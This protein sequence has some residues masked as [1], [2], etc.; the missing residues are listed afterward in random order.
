MQTQFLL[1]NLI[2]SI[3]KHTKNASS[4]RTGLTRAVCDV[5]YMKKIWSKYESIPNSYH[6]KTIEYIKEQGHT[7]ND[8]VWCASEKV[9]GANFSLMTNGVDVLAGSRTQILN[10]KTKFYGGWRKVMDAEKDKVIKAFKLLNERY[11]DKI[12]VVIIY[13]EL[14]GGL[15]SHF[16]QKYMAKNQ[17]CIQKGV[18]YSPSLH[19]YAFDIK[20]DLEMNQNEQKSDDEKTDEIDGRLSVKESIE[21]FEECGFL[22]AKILKQ[23]SFE[24]LMKFDVD[25]MQSTIPRLLNLPPPTDVNTKKEVDNIAE[26]IVIRKL[27]STDHILLK[28]KEKKFLEIEESARQKGKNKKQKNKQRNAGSL[29]DKLEKI[30]ENVLKFTDEAFCEFIQ[31]C[32]NDQ[33]LQSVE[34]KIGKL[35]TEN[36]KKIQGMF[37]GDV[38]E[39]LKKEKSEI[40]SG[41]Q[42]GQIGKVR[43]YI[44]VLVQIFFKTKLEE[45]AKAGANE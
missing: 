27:L 5:E 10:N 17:K 24:E 9:H 43:A 19:F 1:D 26:G 3:E 32:I 13:G 38:F 14:F 35:D 15:Y 29:D 25:N 37:M 20:T 22:H 34:S 12:K 8:I 40:I 18:F 33:R 7:E 42:K 39:E 23:G 30:K 31:R 41:L 2:D 21:I 4:S 36:A 16:D 45:L 11:N 28:I 44:A 6:S